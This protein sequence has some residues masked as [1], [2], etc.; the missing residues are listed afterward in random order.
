MKIEDDTS[1]IIQNQAKCAER[2][3]EKNPLH[4]SK[5]VNYS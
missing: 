4:R 1:K 2:Q 5:G 3:M